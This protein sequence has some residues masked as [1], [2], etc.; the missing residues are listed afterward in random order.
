MHHICQYWIR[1]HNKIQQTTTV[2]SHIN[3]SLYDIIYQMHSSF[4]DSLPRNQ[5]RAHI[6]RHIAK[7]SN[8]NSLN[9][10]KKKSLKC[11]V[12][13]P[14]VLVRSLLSSSSN[15]MC[16]GTHG[17]AIAKQLPVAYT[18]YLNNR[19]V[20]SFTS[21]SEKTIFNSIFVFV[22]LYDYRS[23]DFALLVARV[24]TNIFDPSSLC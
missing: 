7:E 6:Y 11:L 18:T 20:A 9:R 17:Q 8:L 24:G 22:V 14:S 4:H 5:D 23:M 15:L 19:T 10:I 16:P 3:S 1:S 13:V 2:R 21:C 12:G